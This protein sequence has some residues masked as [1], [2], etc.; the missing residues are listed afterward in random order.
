MSEKPNEMPNNNANKPVL[1]TWYH[2]GELVL[3]L[4]AT[5]LGVL[6]LKWH[7]ISIGVLL[8]IFLAIFIAV[9]ILRYFDGKKRNRDRF[10]QGMTVGIAMM[11]GIIVI[12]SLVVY[13]IQGA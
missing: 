6:Y 2:V 13:F 3:L 7:L 1:F 8:P 12:I 5:F 11:P 10:T 9:P 4:I